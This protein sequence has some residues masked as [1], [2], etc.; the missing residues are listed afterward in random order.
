MKKIADVP[1]CISLRKILLS[2][3]YMTMLK[4]TRAQRPSMSRWIVNRVWRPKRMGVLPS[5][6]FTESLYLSWGKQGKQLMLGWLSVTWLYWKKLSSKENRRKTKK[7]RKI[8]LKTTKQKENKKQLET[9]SEIKK[10]KD[11]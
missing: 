11:D 10:K 3:V 1:R 8:Y 9:I 6:R 4:T 5:Y 2:I 7:W